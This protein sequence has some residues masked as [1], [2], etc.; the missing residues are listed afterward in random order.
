MPARAERV[1]LSNRCWLVM[2]AARYIRGSSAAVASTAMNCRML[3]LSAKEPRPTVA[4]GA[5]II[6][7][8]VSVPRA[9][10]IAFDAGEEGLN[11]KHYNDDLVHSC[12]LFH[13]TPFAALC[14]QDPV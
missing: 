11:S 5:L 3:S 2:E 13:L 10:L 12:T 1:D 9:T 6:V 7:M 4:A 8:G 14:S